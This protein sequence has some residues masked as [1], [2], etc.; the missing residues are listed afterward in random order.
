MKIITLKKVK[1]TEDYLR[2]F[3]KKQQ[4]TREDLIVIAETQTDGRG[5]KGRTFS[6]LKGGIYLSYLKFHNALPAKNAFIINKNFSVAVVKTL[7]SF[8]I[9]GK[10]KWPNDIYVNGKKIC[11]MLINNSL[12]GDYIDYTILGIGLNVNNEIPAE[13]L[14]IAV[15]LKDVLGKEIDLNTVIATFVYNLLNFEKVD[16]YARYSMVL[17]E[18]IK[19][20]PRN[21]EPYFAVCK[22]ILPDGR[23]LLTDGKILTAEEVSVRLD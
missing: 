3:L 7:K 8:G 11:G 18:K 12:V 15:S 1:S 4:N 16:L 5:T 17:G 14:D 21:S 22:D 13:L 6:S 23:L 10:I 19:V 9:D 20:L 2:K